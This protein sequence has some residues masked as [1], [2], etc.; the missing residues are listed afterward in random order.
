MPTECYLDLYVF[1][2]FQIYKHLQGLLQS[3]AMATC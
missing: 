3:V 2:Q 1:V